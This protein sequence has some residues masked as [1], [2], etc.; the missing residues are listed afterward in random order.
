MKLVLYD[1]FHSAMIGDMLRDALA[2][3]CEF[4][5]SD[6]MEALR[7]EEDDLVNKAIYAAI[8]ACEVVGVPVRH[9]FRRVFRFSQE[10]IYMDWML[11][12]TACCLVV[13]NADSSWPGVARAQFRLMTDRFS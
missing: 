9:H 5:G 1:P 12:R 7:L 10:G 8:R 2:N 11:S 3:Q 4:Y 13:M 6:L